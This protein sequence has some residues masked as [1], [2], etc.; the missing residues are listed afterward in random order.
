MRLSAEEI[1]DGKDFQGLIGGSQLQHLL[2]LNHARDES[3]ES[4]LSCAHCVASHGANSIH[5]G[6]CDKDGTCKN[7]GYSE[8]KNVRAVGP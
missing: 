7:C 6:D 5:T 8:Y 3:N 4:S 2:L 1:S